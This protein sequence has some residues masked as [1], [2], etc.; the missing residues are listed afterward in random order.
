MGDVAPPGAVTEAFAPIAYAQHQPLKVQD[1]VPVGAHD[2]SGQ[3]LFFL[4]VALSIGGYTSAIAISASAAHLSVLGRV[5]VVDDTGVAVA[6]RTGGTVS[7]L[8]AKAVE[9]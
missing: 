7:R 2:R 8:T 4:L 9:D 5:G 1:V 6:R 3:G